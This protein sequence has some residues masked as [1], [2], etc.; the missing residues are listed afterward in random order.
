MSPFPIVTDGALGDFTVRLC[1]SHTGGRIF[2]Q[3]HMNKQV[4]N[5]PKGRNC[6]Y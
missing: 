4:V 3:S 2:Y 5:V 6:S 1:S